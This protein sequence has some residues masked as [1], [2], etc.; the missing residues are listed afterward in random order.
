MT[1]VIQSLFIHLFSLCVQ[2]IIYVYS[3]SIF[4]SELRVGNV[5]KFISV[6]G[7]EMSYTDLGYQGPYPPSTAAVRNADNSPNS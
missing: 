4:S 1:T 6:L 3:I 7:L 5:P 2:Y